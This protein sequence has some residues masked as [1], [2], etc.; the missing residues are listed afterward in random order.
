MKQIEQAFPGCEYIWQSNGKYRFRVPVANRV[1]NKV[2]D[3]LVKTGKLSEW[4]IRACPTFN[5]MDYWQ[6]E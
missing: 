3:R 1:F 5:D 6:G 2:A 4:L